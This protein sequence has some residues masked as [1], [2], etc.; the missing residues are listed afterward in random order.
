[1]SGWPILSGPNKDGSRHVGMRILPEARARMAA[2]GFVVANKMFTRSVDISAIGGVEIGDVMDVRFD[3][4]KGW[5]VWREDKRLGRLTWSLSSFEA[6]HWRE[7]LPRIDDGTIQV[8]RVVLDAG[9]R[10]INAGGIVRP[11]GMRVPDLI[12]AVPD[13]AIYVPTLRA[14]LDDAAGDALI[15]RE[16]LPGAPRVGTAPEKERDVLHRRFWARLF[17]R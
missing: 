7:G 1:M 6:K 11:R 13:V 14:T 10:V 15:Q 12:E 16:N 2:Q 4:E 9:G 17:R 8:T 5:W 3:G